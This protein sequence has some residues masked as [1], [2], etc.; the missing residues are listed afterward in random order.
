MRF[1][2]V[3][4]LDEAVAEN[5]AR[6]LAKWGYEARFSDEQRCRVTYNILQC[7]GIECKMEIGFDT[8][9]EHV[10]PAWG[11][12]GAEVRISQ[13]LRVHEIA[14]H[15]EWLADFLNQVGPQPDML[16]LLLRH[17]RAVLEA[18]WRLGGADALRNFLFPSVR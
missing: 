16:S 14:M 2:E 17:D 12:G 10:Q 9:T 18:A 1:V 7:V 3:S 8:E 4:D 13:G 6:D 11:M 15:E 5:R